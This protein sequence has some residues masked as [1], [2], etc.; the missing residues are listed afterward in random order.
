MGIAMASDALLD[1][2]DRWVSDSIE[3]CRQRKPPYVPSRFMLMREEMKAQY[4]KRGTVEAINRLLRSSEPQRG[5]TRMVEIGLKEWTLEWA[6]AS[7][8]FRPLFPD[9]LVQANA[10][11]RLQGQL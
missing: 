4:G 10:Q 3:R 7:E 6:V 5:F 1:E 9:K 11:A 2:L 8:K